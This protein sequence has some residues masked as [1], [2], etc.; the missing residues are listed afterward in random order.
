MYQSRIEAAADPRLMDQAAAQ[1]GVLAVGCTDAAGQVQSVAA[2]VAEQ[3][4]TLTDLQAVMASLET[5]QRQVTDATDEARMLSDNARKRLTDGASIVATSIAEFSQLTAMVTR[6]GTQ[7]TGFS[8]AMEQV[9]RTTQIID[10]IARTTNMLA[11]NAAIEAEKAG[12]AG[13]TFAVV[14]AEV[15]KLAQDTRAA[16]DE[17]GITMDSLTS[18]GETFVSE[19]QNG[20][21][22]SRQ[23]EAGF[24]RINETVAEVID[25]V[26]QVDRQTDDIARSTSLIHD[27]VCRV[28][29]ELDGFVDAAKANSDRLGGAIAHIGSLEIGANQMLDMIVHSGFAPADRHFVDIALVA[30]DTVAGAVEA[31]IASNILPS[32]AVFDT[33]YRPVAG[34]NPPQFETRFCATA[35]QIVQPLLD[36]VVAS[37]ERITG[38]VITDMTGYLPTHIS[39]R[40]LPQ[41]PDDPAWNAL[42]CR[43]K[44]NFMDDATARAIASDADFMLTTYRQNLGVHGYRTVKN[45]FVPLYFGGKR[46]GNLEVA[47]AIDD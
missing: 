9:R 28:G 19:I 39:A 5:D 6:L 4:K 1:C 37:D 21:A 43:N 23:A 15:K 30:T 3:A 18:E 7:I 33:D 25:L 14:A 26:G 12:E 8:S 31:A 41:R 36:A 20:M 45:V 22:R 16:I 11:L 27:S 38:A 24:A 32:D 2:S 47:Y 42:N 35:D 17:I 13:R 40:S 44:C 29:D 34:S 46:W 10:G